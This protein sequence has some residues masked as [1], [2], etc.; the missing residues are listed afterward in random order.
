V[1]S[2]RCSRSGER[3]CENPDCSSSTR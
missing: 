3:C 1:A 2:N